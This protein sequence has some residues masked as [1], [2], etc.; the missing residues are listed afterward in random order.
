VQYS[1]LVVPL[2]SAMRAMRTRIEELEKK[3]AALES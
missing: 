2:L 3:V 1:R